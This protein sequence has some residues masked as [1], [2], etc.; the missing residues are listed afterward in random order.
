MQEKTECGHENLLNRSKFS[1]YCLA[2]G[3]ERLKQIISNGDQAPPEKA[4]AP[5]STE[6]MATMARALG[7]RGGKVG[8]RKRWEGVSKE[9]RDAH[10]AKM[11]AARMAKLAAKKAAR[12]EEEEVKP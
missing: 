1:C 9:Q 10:M 7:H 5:A 12:T 11:R 6:L 8:G 4:A 3:I 2:V